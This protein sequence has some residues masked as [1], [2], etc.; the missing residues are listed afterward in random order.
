MTVARRTASTRAA[1]SVPSATPQAG[2]DLFVS[3]WV[4]GLAPAVVLP[5]SL[6]RFVFIKLA[7]VMGACAVIVA[8]PALGRLTRET[9]IF[10]SG[11]A[12]LLGIAAVSSP[13]PWG[14]LI[15]R[16]PRY[17][18]IVSLGVYAAALFAGARVL[19]PT[20]DRRLRTHLLRATGLAGGVMAVVALLEA[21]G[22]HP[23]STSAS[24]PGS[25]LGNATEQGA[26]GVGVLALGLVMGASTRWTPT[27]ITTAVAGGV[28]VTT[29]ASRGALLG[30]AAAMALAGLLG[31]RPVRRTTLV[32]VA[33]LAAGVL[34]VPLSRS[35]VLLQ[36]PLST[37]TMTG[38]WQEW[39]TVWSLIRHHPLGVGP[40]G[41]VD[42][43][44]GVEPAAY[45]R[46]A[47]T[48][49]LDSPHSVPLQ[50]AVAGGLP[51]LLV[52]VV[53][54][55]AMGRRVLREAP[56]TKEPW[57]TAAGCAL[58][59]WA[60]VMV[61]HF[62]A[63]GSTPFFCLLA[64]SLLSVPR[65]RQLSRGRRLASSV[66]AGAAVITLL[67]AAV[68][69]IP[70]RQGLVALADGRGGAA[71]ADFAAARSLRPWDADLDAQIAHALVVVPATGSPLAEASNYLRRAE[72]AFPDDPWIKLDMAQHELA[73]GNPQSALAGLDRA[74]QRAPTTAVIYLLRGQVRLRTGDQSG[75]INDLRT[76][77]FLAPTDP[78]PLRVLATAYA[79][80]GQQDLAALALKRASA[81]AHQDP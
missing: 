65:D 4:L 32:T 6:N 34:V 35:R 22:V 66:L 15:G 33:I 67:A 28:L 13:A 1:R 9:R 72:Q 44:P 47:G 31:T 25:L 38:R 49:I 43:W 46:L 62:T 55:V 11:G 61:T 63:P 21:A 7:L 30:A 16:A 77:A 23:L 60:V 75:A 71:T 70:L 3:V 64:G 42:A 10:L 57:S 18:G 41:F 58:A 56:T 68:A 2:R 27:T 19:G 78:A 37:Q 12:V 17:E 76:A 52:A 54:A 48:A 53:F 14:Q 5:E 69:E 36:S 74:Q 50:I 51:L 29:S 39:F 59:G 80:A 45:A 26:Y 81:L 79:Q 40:S 24:R 20:G 73:S 8:R